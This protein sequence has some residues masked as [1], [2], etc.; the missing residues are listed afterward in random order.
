MNNFKIWLI[1]FLIC[2]AI[3]F[4]ISYV[5]S[6]DLGIFKQNTCVNLY[7]YCDNCTFVNL[8][9]VQ[10][11]NGTILTINDLMTKDGIDYNYTFC[12]TDTFGT[13]YYT[14]FGDKDG[15]NSTE[16]LNF[17]INYRGEKVTEAQSILY[18]GLLVVFIL[19]FLFIFFIIGKLPDGNQRDEEGR[20]LSISYLKYL[21]PALWFVEWMLFIGMLYLSSNLAFAYLN[22]QLFAKVLFTI[23]RIC[24]GFTPIIVIVWIIHIFVSMF[25]DKQFQQML[26][27]GIFPQG[28]L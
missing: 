3:L 4:S 14:V 11:P 2:L 13:Y 19:T 23:F 26:N 1:S 20:I 25:H 17:E 27:R 28:K 5:S 10:Y 15:Y 16:R 21:R 18:I 22:E 24:F 6:T 12:G 9:K 7:Q 8:T